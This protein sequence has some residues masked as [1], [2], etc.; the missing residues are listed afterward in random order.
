MDSVPVHEISLAIGRLGIAVILW[1]LLLWELSQ[2]AGR[3]A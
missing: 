3:R 2:A 1:G